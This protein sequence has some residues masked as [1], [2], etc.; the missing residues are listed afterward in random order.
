[1]NPFYTLQALPAAADS[2]LALVNLLLILGILCS[3]ALLVVS[4]RQVY[5]RGRIEGFEFMHEIEPLSPY[6]PVE[7]YY[8]F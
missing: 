7:F 6:E 4:R 8:L 1:M 2:L 5:E 3:I